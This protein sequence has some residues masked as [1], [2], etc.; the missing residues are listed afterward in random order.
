[1]TSV[2]VESGW[3]QQPARGAELLMTHNMRSISR[4]TSLLPLIVILISGLVIY[5]KFE[6][7]P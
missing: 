7:N 5:L 1:M 3:T 6:L 2:M 4:V